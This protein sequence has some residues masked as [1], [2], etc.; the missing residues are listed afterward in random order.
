[1]KTLQIEDMANHS[2]QLMKLEKQLY[3]SQNKVQQLEVASVKDQKILA[4]LKTKLVERISIYETGMNTQMGKLKSRL[5]R[6]EE[7][8]GKVKKLFVEKL[9]ELESNF[10][11][12]GDH[13]IAN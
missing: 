6:R 12:I 9:K 7:E 1:M 13:I 2:S 4:L 11:E 8:L 5:E 3:D 10:A